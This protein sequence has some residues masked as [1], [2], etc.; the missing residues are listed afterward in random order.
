MYIPLRQQMFYLLTGK[1]D[2][3]TL[4]NILST[5]VTI[6]A[7]ALV[8]IAYPEVTQVLS[9]IGGL[10]GV[11][12]SY[13]IPTWSYVSL[14][15]RPIRSWYIM[16]S[17][18]AFGLLTLVGYFSVLLTIYQIFKGNPYFGNGE[19]QGFPPY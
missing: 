2:C 6:G 8:A 10:C 9:I 11:S 3:T 5:A 16:C 1:E 18:L 17:I 19:C 14:S 12:I 15:G 7:T 13:V 4:Q